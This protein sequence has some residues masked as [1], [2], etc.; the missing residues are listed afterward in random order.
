VD[1]GIPF[2]DDTFILASL[3]KA[4]VTSCNDIHRLVTGISDH[5]DHAAVSMT[6]YSCMHRA[7]FL[8]GSTPSRLAKYFCAKADEK[9]RWACASALGIG[10]F[11]APADAV[12]DAAFTA[13]RV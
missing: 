7:D 4:A 12:P 9:L 3:D 13:D 2:G 11:A 5:R 8:A 10:L 1:C 6:Y